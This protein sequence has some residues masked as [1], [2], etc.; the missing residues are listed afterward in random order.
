MESDYPPQILEYEERFVFRFNYNVHLFDFKFKNHIHHFD[1]NP[2]SVNLTLGMNKNDEL[3][4]F[5]V[6]DKK[7][8]ITVLSQRL[9]FIKQYELD[10][11]N[12]NKKPIEYLKDFTG[13]VHY[14]LESL[15]PYLRPDVDLLPYD[16]FV[17]REDGKRTLQSLKVHIANVCY[18]KYDGVLVLLLENLRAQSREYMIE[19][20]KKDIN[21][22]EK[23]RDKKID[24]FTPTNYMTCGEKYL[25]MTHE[26]YLCP[27]RIYNKYTFENANPDDI[28]GH[29][30]V[31]CQDYKTWYQMTLKLLEK[32]ESIDKLSLDV[33]KIILS[34]IS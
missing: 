2:I 27:M 26:Q 9:Q 32:I 23:I 18:D 13:Y 14:N 30:P 12:I 24:T 4:V 20:W 11:K 5:D 33:L 25:I 3:M 16:A 15:Q 1:I 28:P 8:K 6:K 7:S 19:F 21:K 34:Y 31:F 10:N 17:F 29:L 22:W